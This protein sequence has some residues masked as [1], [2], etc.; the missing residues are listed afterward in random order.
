MKSW[1]SHSKAN[2]FTLIELLVVI[3]IIGV[4][5]AIGIPALKGLNN[6]NDISTANRQLIDDLSFAR[7]SAINSRTTVY[8][9]FLTPQI[10]KENWTPR[11]WAEIRKIIDG[12]Y[13]SYALFA[14]R[15]LGDQPG[16]GN[17]HYL[18][19]WKSLPNGTFIVTNKFQFRAPGQV[20]PG[21][22]VDRGLPQYRIPFPEATNAVI[23]LPCIAFDY[24]GRLTEPGDV[25]LPIAK[26]AV[27]VQDPDAKQPPEVIETPRNNFTNNPVVRIDWLT[28][29]ARSEEYTRF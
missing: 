2:A 24:L 29:R 20:V 3:A 18:T 28:G 10:L 17:A 6:T 13:S 11:Q 23:S 1:N 4:M 14:N 16:P 5:A 7:I 21:Y 27:I 22:L 15:S 12:Q 25:I 9:V 19:D 8:V 26:G